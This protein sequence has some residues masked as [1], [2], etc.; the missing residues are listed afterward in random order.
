MRDAST[1]VSPASK[2]SCPIDVSVMG[3]A[4]SVATKASL[5]SEGIP[6]T[7]ATTRP[8]RVG[9]IQEPNRH[10]RDGS[11]YFHTLCKVACCPSLPP[12]QARRVF[13]THPSTRTLTHGDSLARLFGEN[14]S[15]RA[16]GIRA[17][18]ASLL[19]VCAPLLVSFEYES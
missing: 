9:W 10:A 11:K 17:R 6:R 13:Q 3:K 7:A 5:V 2:I 19:L 4:A 1:S 15:L 12:W 16:R 8:R 18:E 14:L